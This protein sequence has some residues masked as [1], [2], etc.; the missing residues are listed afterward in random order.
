MVLRPWTIERRR[1]LFSHP[2]IVVTEETV[3]LPDG[4]IVE[5]YLQIAVAEHV[6]MIV[7]SDDGKILLQRQYKHGPR[8]VVLTFPAGEIE[9]TEAPADAARRELQEETGFRARD[10]RYFG[11]VVLNGNQGA[12]AVHLFLAEG[13]EDAGRTSSATDADLEE[14]EL[15]WLTEAELVEAAKDGQFRISSHALALALALNPRLWPESV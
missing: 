5:D 12:G 7:R 9:P 13:I 14:Q 1:V 2:R 3:R 11:R 10:W 15:L 6:V 8:A 4:R